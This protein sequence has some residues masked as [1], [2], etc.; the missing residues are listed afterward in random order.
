MTIFLILERFPDE[1]NGDIDK[2]DFFFA[3]DNEMCIWNK[4]IVTVSNIFHVRK[5][6]MGKI[7]IKIS[8]Q[9]NGIFIV[10]EYEILMT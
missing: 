10:T 6:Y 9:I 5:S 1:T 4:Y 3:S 7:P 2:C 8:R